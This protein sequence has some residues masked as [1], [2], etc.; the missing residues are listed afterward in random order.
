MVHKEKIYIYL[1]LSE[2]SS[3]SSSLLL[4]QIQRNKSLAF[5]LLS[6]LSLGGLVVD[7]ENTGNGLAD[8]TNLGELGGSTTSHLSNSELKQ[9]RVKKYLYHQK[10]HRYYL[11]Q[12]ELKVIQLLQQL[13]LALIAESVGLNFH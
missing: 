8:N 4:S 2:S 10:G 7:S 9:K 13:R 5:V 3:D 11:R 6:Q 1:F 12:L